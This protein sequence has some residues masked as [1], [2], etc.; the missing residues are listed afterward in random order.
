MP[1]NSEKFIVDF[2]Y[3]LSY[4]GNIIDKHY[5]LLL[6]KAIFLVVT[7]NDYQL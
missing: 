3:G 5:Q 1:F 7:D 2:S 4:S 6:R